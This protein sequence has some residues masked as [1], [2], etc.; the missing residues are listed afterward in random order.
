[1]RAA[2]WILGIALAVVLLAVAAALIAALF[3]NPD[4]YRG[5][6]QS[7]V[8]NATGRPFI[9]Q[10]HLRLTFFPWL[11]VRMGAARLGPPPGASGPDLLDWQSARVRVRLL[12]LLLHRQLEIGR[13]R[14]RGAHLHLLRGPNGTDSWD[15]L[16]RRLEA[17]GPAGAGRTAPHPAGWG[18]LDLLDSSLD[19]V[20]ERSQEHIRLTAWRLEIGPWHPGQPFSARTRFLLH[21]DTTGPHAS[22]VSPSGLRLPAEGIRIALDLPRLGI[23]TS[24]LEVSAPDWS[25]R[26][27][28]AR[29]RGALQA[30][31]NAS[32]HLSAS[33]SLTAA[34]PSL[35]GLAARLG[36]DLPRPADPRALGALSLAARW[37]YRLDTLTVAPLTAKLDA[38]TLTGW[39]AHAGGAQPAWRFA[40]RADQLD[41]GRYLT[42]SGQHQPLALH[43]SA[44]RALHARGTL[45]LAR[46]RLDGTTFTD[47]HLQVQ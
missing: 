13:I 12:P 25:L 33:G 11:G 14:V 46:A 45:A 15:D 41:V 38:T 7:A 31:R 30:R 35:R 23:R 27:A 19:Y 34:I 37:R 24:P 29:L 42:S 18:G 44:L 16:S 2:R 21:L 10:G 28:D 43:V 3:I 4:R 9:V 39:L 5:D 26:I 17:S 1:M 6:L 47:V 36:V 22:P 32:A 20:D 40:L 8:R